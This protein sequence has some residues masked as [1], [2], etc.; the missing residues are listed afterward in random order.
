MI[1]N[2][3]GHHAYPPPTANADSSH[4]KPLKVSHSSDDHSGKPTLKSLATGLA[5]TIVLHPAAVPAEFLVYMV[6]YCH[7]DMLDVA[8][9]KMK[10]AHPTVVVPFLLVIV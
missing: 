3:F 4:Q 2:S 9:S 7:P 10:A 1:R 5:F 8:F 6:Y